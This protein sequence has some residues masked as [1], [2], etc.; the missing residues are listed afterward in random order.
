MHNFTFVDLVTQVEWSP[1]DGSLLLVAIGKRSL[2]FVK[3]LH[4]PDWHCKID[5]GIAGLA[6]AQWGP[7]NNHVLTVSDFK[8]R[9][10]I[11]GLADKSVQYIKSP[12]HEDGRGIAFSPSRKLM[13]VAQ[14]NSEAKDAIG[15]YDVGKP[16]NCLTT[17]NPDTFDLEDLRF[18]G[19]GQSLIVWDSNLKCKILIYQLQIQ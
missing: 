8:V 5:E 13:A 7:G 10:T 1:V 4:D 15:V 18:S 6:H 14:R 16:W 3:S 12:K 11:W 2:V 17:F 9:L 19:D